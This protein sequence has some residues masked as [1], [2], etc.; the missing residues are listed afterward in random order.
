MP[1]TVICDTSPLFYLHR[2]GCLE[3]LEKLY[4]VI[5]VPQAVA[6]ELKEGRMQGMDVPDVRKFGWMIGAKTFF[7]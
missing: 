6:D 1:D 7:R 3:L 2:A 5:T 4:H